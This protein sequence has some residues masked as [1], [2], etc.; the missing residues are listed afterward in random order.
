MT[1]LYF[2]C[3]HAVG[4]H[5]WTPN[6]TGAERVVH[7]WGRGS[8]GID[9]KL[10]PGFRNPRTGIVDEQIEGL[11]TLTH[12]DG[13]TAIAF[14]DRSVDERGGSNSAFL[15]PDPLLPWALAESSARIAFP[16][17]WARF[18]FD[19]REVSR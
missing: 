3:W 5:L 10:P 19:V 6:A 4:H 16:T 11:A 12:L 8:R 17:I 18:T 9:G 15:L 14:W 1:P 7:P 2:G 13:W